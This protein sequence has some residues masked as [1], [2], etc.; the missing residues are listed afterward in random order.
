MIAASKILSCFA[1]LLAALL[2]AGE[3][4]AA[5][6]YGVY[7]LDSATVNDVNGVATPVGQSALVAGYTF[8]CRFFGC[9][10]DGTL[11]TVATTLGVNTVAALQ[12]Y[13]LPATSRYAGITPYAFINTAPWQKYAVEQILTSTASG[14]NTLQFGKTITVS[15]AD[16]SSNAHILM[17]AG[18]LS[19]IRPGYVVTPL[20]SA[21]SM[22]GSYTVG[23]ISP[24][25][26]DGTNNGFVLAAA[27]S[28]AP[29]AGDTFTVAEPLGYLTAALAAGLKPVVAGAGIPVGTTITAVNITTGVVT[30]SASLTAATTAF[31]G[32]DITLPYTD[33]EVAAMSMDTLGINAAIYYAASHGGGAA[34][35]PSGSFELNQTITLSPANQNYATTYQAVDLLGTGENATLLISATDLGW[36]QYAISCPLR[37]TSGNCFGRLDDFTLQ[38]ANTT[39]GPGQS[40]TLMGGI[41][42]DGRRTMDNIRIV[43]YGDGVAITGDQTHFNNI[44]GFGNYDCLHWDFNNTYNS[45]DN[46]VLSKVICGNNAMAAIAVGPNV[47]VAGSLF[48]FFTDGAGPFGIEKETGGTQSSALADDIFDWPQFEEVSIAARGEDRPWLSHTSNDTR[49]DYNMM[50][51]QRAAM[52]T[53]FFNIAYGE[54]NATAAF[55]EASF[56][57]VKVEPSD[58]YNWSAGAQGLFNVTDASYG[59]DIDGD[60][61]GLITNSGGSVFG[62][63]TNSGRGWNFNDRNYHAHVLYST[64]SLTTG[65]LS[66]LVE[67][68][69][70]S[71]NTQTCA[72]GTT[73]DPIGVQ[74]QASSLNTSMHIMLDRGSVTPDSTG[75]VLPKTTSNAF[76]IYGPQIMCTATNGGVQPGQ[77]RA[78]P[79]GGVPVGTMFD[80]GNSFSQVNTGT[81]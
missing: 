41:G 47:V 25:G 39:Y 69:T 35:I 37:I 70:S 45:H 77:G 81:W 4:Q 26:T 10:G 11:H 40:S 59:V 61:L 8:N 30:L 75:F 57:K 43:S 54:A 44:T 17:A 29:T 2:P 76:Y 12:T 36:G 74:L 73:D 14:S 18:G 6:N 5:S 67:S 15:L 9:R 50:E 21:N 49:V 23:T 7:Q 78:C 66:C 28:V 42:W 27:P 32:V 68:S 19:A 34:Q 1:A 60:V 51:F 33:A 53:A 24:Q 55:D 56:V 52:N 71:A 38:S 64:A 20:S 63:D 80:S 31:D 48:D 65:L 72:G 79:N 16:S 22:T 13:K 62:P 58:T 3:A 46:H